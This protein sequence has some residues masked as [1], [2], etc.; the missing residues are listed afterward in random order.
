MASLLFL[1]SSLRSK[2]G[3]STYPSSVGLSSINPFFHEYKSS[4]GRSGFIVLVS[5]T[6]L[7]ISLSDASHRVAFQ[8]AFASS[9]IFN[10][11][12]LSLSFA[13]NDCCSNIGLRSRLFAPVGTTLMNSLDWSILFRSCD[14]VSADLSRCCFSKRSDLAMNLSLNILNSVFGSR[15]ILS[16]H[17]S[18]VIISAKSVR[19][20]S[21]ARLSSPVVSL[22]SRLWSFRAL[23]LNFHDTTLIS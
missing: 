18:F 21:R 1:F 12:A 19:S 7:L 10:V 13:D 4:F 2:I 5:S 17:V 23:W 16:I 20:N 11:F 22:F 8:C 9:N 14:A 3:D 6:S 15:S